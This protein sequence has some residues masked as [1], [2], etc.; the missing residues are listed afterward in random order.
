MLSR[1]HMIVLT[2]AAVGVA[3][4]PRI[5]YADC[6]KPRIP[7]MW[8]DGPPEYL[9]GAPLRN[10]L[11][12]DQTRKD[13]VKLFGTVMTTRCDSIAGARLDFW[14]TDSNGEYDTRGFRFRGAQYSGGNG[15]YAL[16]T[17]MPGPYSG[18]RHV[19]FLV[20][21]RLADRLQPLI[22]SGAVFLPTPQEYA[23]AKP[24]HRTPEFLA[25]DSLRRVDGTLLVPCDIVLA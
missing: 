17:L 13:R 19:H 21:V 24:S 3:S 18:P 23:H 7:S 5:A 6:G 14:H 9:P 20:A 8:I 2:S 1:R 22:V 12:E 11:I 10:S 15:D 4:A 16:E 25:P